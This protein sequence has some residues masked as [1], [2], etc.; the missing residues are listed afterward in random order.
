MKILAQGG[1]GPEQDVETLFWNCACDR[2]DLKRPLGVSSGARRPRAG[3]MRESVDIQPM[4]A[5]M[6]PVRPRR[7]RF[8]LLIAMSRAGHR[9]LR[10][11]KGSDETG[12]RLCPNV[13]RMR[14]ATPGARRHR[15]R[16][17]ATAAGLFMKWAWKWPARSRS[18]SQTIS[19]RANWLNSSGLAVRIRSPKKTR[20]AAR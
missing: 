5:Q 10:A 2:Q 13:L 3:K 1:E 4:I 19:A 20:S 14:R 7:Q 18:R 17:R 16:M 6:N 8:Q 12:P 9:P 15:G 11:G